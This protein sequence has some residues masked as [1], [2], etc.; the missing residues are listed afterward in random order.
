MIRGI[1]VCKTYQ[2]PAPASVLCPEGWA[3]TR[4]WLSWRFG[5]QSTIRAEN[6]FVHMMAHMPSNKSTLVVRI[7]FL[8]ALIGMLLLVSSPPDITRLVMTVVIDTIHRMIRCWS[9]T[10]LLKP[11]LKR[12]E[13][14]LNPPTAIIFVAGKSW[15]VATCLGVLP[16]VVLRCVGHIMGEIAR[17]TVL[18]FI[19]PRWR[20]YSSIVS[21]N[22]VITDGY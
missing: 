18:P 17:M 11:L 19:Q 14:E 7:T 10:Q 20:L 22:K 12:I 16:S 15:I 2:V 4:L 13:Q 1:P 3:L 21:P 5:A 9:Q 6:I 8:W